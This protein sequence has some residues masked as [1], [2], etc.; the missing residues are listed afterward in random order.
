LTTFSSL[1]LTT[2]LCNVYV[3]LFGLIKENKL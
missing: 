1:P 3:R 2:P